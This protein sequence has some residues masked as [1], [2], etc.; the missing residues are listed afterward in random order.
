MVY[1]RGWSRGI[2]DD[3]LITDKIRKLVE[4]TDNMEGLLVLHATCGGTGSGTAAKVAEFTN[5]D[6]GRKKLQFNYSLWPSPNQSSSVIEPYNAIFALQS[7]IE[8]S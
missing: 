8:H 2:I 3:I 4:K 7:L 5:V 1:N 6:F